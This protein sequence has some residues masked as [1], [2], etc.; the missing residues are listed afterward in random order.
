MSTELDP[1]FN[2]KSVAIVGI[3][4][5]EDSLG[6][7]LLRNLH[8]FG[9][10]GEIHPVNRRAVSIQGLKVYKDL[11]EIPTVPDMVISFLPRD[12][13]LTLTEECVA[14]GV[15]VLLIITAGFRESG[16]D[17]FELEMKISKV[18]QEGELRVVGPNSMGVLNGYGPLLNASFSPIPCSSG[19]IGLISQSGAL[20]AVIMQYANE[21]GLGFSKFVS[22]GN[23]LDI[24]ANHLLEYYSKDTHTKVILCYMESFA[25][26]HAFLKIARDVAKDKPIVMVKSGT[27]AQGSKAAMSHTGALAGNDKITDAALASC[28]VIRTKTIKDMVD[29]SLGLQKSPLPSGR[30]VAIVSNAGGPGTLTTDFA[31]DHD[32]EI[33][34]LSSE[35]LTGLMDILP[36]EATVSNPVDILPSADSSVYKEVT[37]LLLND[38]NVDS[39]IVLALPP[40][41]IQLQDILDVLT[42]LK[43]VSTKPL[44]CVAMGCEEELDP[45]PD[46]PFPVYRYPITA[47]M[48][49]SHIVRYAEWLSRDS[50]VEV[51]PSHPHP[52]LEANRGKTLDQS[53][54]AKVLQDY[55]FTLP[56]QGVAGNLNEVLE[57]ATN[58]GYPLV[59]KLASVTLSH[60]S[61]HEGVFLNVK[62]EDDLIRVYER[63]QNIYI[64]NNVSDDDRD[65]LIQEYII[66]GIEVVLGVV[67]DPVFG[68]AVMVGSG[69]TLVELL[70]DI[71]FLSVPFQSDD[72]MSKLSSLKVYQLLEGYRGDAGGDVEGL[73]SQIMQLQQ[74]VLDNPFLE[75]MDINPL[76]SLPQR[77]IVV[78][79]R[80]KLS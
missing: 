70:D 3:S 56:K 8:S 57:V 55:G 18:A 58:V 19:N 34:E 79:A 47:G 29:V 30:K 48:V 12:S 15:S 69:G 13:V 16:Q 53:I 22:I 50:N 62:T 64:E 23:K 9:L 49:L 24:N 5:R 52:L 54:V 35:T 42:E 37:A 61:E 21:L 67:K 60:K 65:V 10:L 41:L 2:P 31:V 14:L 45:Y 20:G 44:I 74:L 46:T 71:I 51:K 32:L 1:V 26:P 27:T 59:I 63:I 80:I 4:R 11:K 40:V 7:K 33:A 25:D 72:V 73:I 75:E 68:H 66:K 28:G 17:G 77:N 43:V 76:I 36:P 38:P 78:D 6:Q 39:V